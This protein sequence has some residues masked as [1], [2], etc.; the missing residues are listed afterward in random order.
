MNPEGKASAIVSEHGA[1]SP[2]LKAL[3]DELGGDW[4]MLVITEGENK[5]ARVVEGLC[6][7]GQL[8]PGVEVIRFHGTTD[9]PQ[10]DHDGD[11][12]AGGSKPRAKRK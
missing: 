8:P 6:N 12:K 1:D 2:L 4:T 5:S 3:F 9:K 7:Y 11:G 10:L